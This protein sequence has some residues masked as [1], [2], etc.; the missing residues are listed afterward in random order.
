[1]IGSVKTF[2]NTNETQYTSRGA[3]IMQQQEYNPDVKYDDFQQQPQQQQPQQYSQPQYSQYPQPQYSQ[4]QYSQPPPVQV[5][6][7]SSHSIVSLEGKQAQEA[8]NMAIIIALI[9]FF[10]FTPVFAFVPFLFVLKYSRSS[11]P[12][13]KHYGSL[14]RTCAIVF[15]G[16]SLCSVLMVVFVIVLWAIIYGVA[17]ARARK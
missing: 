9:I 10:V 15:A 1:M 14:A 13:A 7:D 16:I 8:F 5:Y 11:D 12:Q 4:P 2:W 6:T 17:I 3:H